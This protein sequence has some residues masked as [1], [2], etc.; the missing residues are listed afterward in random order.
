MKI[1]TRIIGYVKNCLKCCCQCVMT[2]RKLSELNETAFGNLEEQE[3]DGQL[4]FNGFYV[5]FVF[6]LFLENYIC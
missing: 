2:K 6:G 3:D 1:Y 4:L 5:L